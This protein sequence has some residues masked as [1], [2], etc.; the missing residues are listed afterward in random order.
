M[1]ILIVGANGFVGQ[2]LTEKLLGLGHHVWGLVRDKNKVS[3][4]HPNFHVVE[5]DLLGKLPDLSGTALDTAYYLAHG[6]KSAHEHFEYYEVKAA[7]QFASWWKKL[8]GQK[9]IYLGGLGP[10]DEELSPHLRSRQITGKIL[11]LGSNCLEFR[12]S[13]ILGGKSLSYEMIRALSERLP[14]RADLKLLKTQC[15][16]LSLSDLL[17][18][19]IA[20]LDLNIK[21]HQVIQI[22]GNESLSYGELL[23]RYIEKEKLKRKVIKIPDVDP[24]VFTKFL[25]YVVPEY[26]DV[27]KKLVES[28]FHE[29][30]VTDN[31]AKE[32]FPHIHPKTLNESL[33][34]AR[35][36]SPMEYHAVWDRDFLK[37]LLSDK[38]LTQSG[39]F[40]PEVLQHF[41]KVMRLK[42][43]VSSMTTRKEK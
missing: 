26:S 12:A 8:S 29:T 3:F 23:D 38:I 21:G 16:P 5:G 34:E 19:L 42:E 28:L 41:E 13:I 6:M 39:L 7:T 43:F 30:I 40:S 36:Q 24:I 27:G 2:N 37:K 4:S 15:Q 11:A 31:S 33:D 17:D 14:F 1:N 18:Y 20:A 32:F 25:D 10:E 35:S 22:G 9:V